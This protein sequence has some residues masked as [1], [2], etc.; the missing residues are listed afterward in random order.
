MKISVERMLLRLETRRSF[1]ISGLLLWLALDLGY[2]F[3]VNPIH[4]YSGFYL[5]ISWVKYIEGLFLY[6][7]LLII[8]P[9]RLRRP[10]D[11]FMNFLL[12]GLIA[13]LLLFYGLSDQSRAY[14]YVVLLGYVIIDWFRRGRLVRIRG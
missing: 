9:R 13:P 6:I 10:S 12:F 3:Y 4:A 11:Y 7:L 8:A 14:L 5:N 1:V 2:R